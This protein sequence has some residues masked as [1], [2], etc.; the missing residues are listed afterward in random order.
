VF[1]HLANGGMIRDMGN[2]IAFTAHD[3]AT[4]EAALLFAQAKWGKAFSLD[5]KFLRFQPKER[6]NENIPER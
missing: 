1:I 2:E 4:K 5:G 6:S 3:E